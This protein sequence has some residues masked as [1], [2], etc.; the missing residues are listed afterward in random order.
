RFGFNFKYISQ[1]IYNYNANALA[2]DA[3]VI[4]KIFSFADIAAVIKNIGTRF[5]YTKTDEELPMQIRGGLTLKF[6]DDL[7]LNGELIYSKDEELDMVAAAEYK[8]LKNFALRGAFNTVNDAGSGLTFGVG[9]NADNFAVDYAYEDY[10]DF[11]SAHKMS[12]NFKF[13]VDKKVKGKESLL[14]LKL[15]TDKKSKETIQEAVEDY[16]KDGYRNF[17]EGKYLN[18]MLSFK[19]AVQLDENNINARLWLAYSFVKLGD[20]IRAIQEY[21][22][23]LILDPSNIN[24][25]QALK[26][27]GD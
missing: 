17:Q 10:G 27:L 4:Y 22:K 12:M 19:E 1:S 2:L 20:R 13:G 7:L 5:K 8:I 11:S 25:R 3:G 14:K 9:F 16:I 23:V 6:I 18:A 24:A 15:F 26:I 21:K